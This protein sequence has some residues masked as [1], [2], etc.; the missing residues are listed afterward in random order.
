MNLK[1]S[2][3]QRKKVKQLYSE[4]RDKLSGRGKYTLNDIERI[5]GVKAKAAWKIVYFN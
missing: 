3:E 4:D 5:T 1:Y 2:E